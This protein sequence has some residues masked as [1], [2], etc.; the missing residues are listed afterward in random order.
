MTGNPAIN[1]SLGDQC[2][3]ASFTASGTM[4]INGTEAAETPGNQPL[5]CN[6]MVN[7]LARNLIFGIC[8]E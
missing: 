8:R 6:I 3:V 4:S 7:E 1:Y 2:S 5:N